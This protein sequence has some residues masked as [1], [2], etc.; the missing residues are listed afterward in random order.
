M[1][2][3]YQ[4]PHTLR[5]F[6]STSKATPRPVTRTCPPAATTIFTRRDASGWP[7][8]GRRRR[9]ITLKGS[10]EYGRHLMCPVS[11]T[12]HCFRQHA[13]VVS[14][15]AFRICNLAP[16]HPRRCCS[17]TNSVFPHVI[18]RFLLFRYS[19]ETAGRSPVKTAPTS[20]SV[21]CRC[22]KLFKRIIRFQIERARK[23]TGKRNFLGEWKGGS[24]RGSLGGP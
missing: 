20:D 7:K 2:H 5:A 18:E 9:H 4:R 11:R 15:D 8:S 14:F 17:Y 23:S 22:A 13:V 21:H 12:T 6:A 16:G 19:P 24:D 3:L 1:E 10:Y